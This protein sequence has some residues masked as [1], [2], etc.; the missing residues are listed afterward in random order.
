MP[1][2]AQDFAARLSLYKSELPRRGLVLLLMGYLPGVALLA[3]LGALCKALE[4]PTWKL[5]AFATAFALLSIFFIGWFF[6]L[7]MIGL[8]AKIGL[9]CPGCRR[10]SVID[11][12]PGQLRRDGRCPRCG[13]PLFEPA[14]GAPVVGAAAAPEGG[15]AH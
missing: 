13:E 2:T 12:D 7:A 11:A 4:P 9:L 6:Y 8:P 15:P 1:V 10:F 3:A 5:L 14:G